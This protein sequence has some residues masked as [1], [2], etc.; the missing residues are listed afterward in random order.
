MNGKKIDVITHSSFDA[1]T[2]DSFQGKERKIVIYSLVVHKNLLAL[3]DFRRLNVAIT[4]AR[5]K[6]IILASKL[7]CDSEINKTRGKYYDLLH[8]HISLL[9]GI[10]TG[11]HS[12]ELKDFID[13][14]KPIAQNMKIRGMQLDKDEQESLVKRRLIEP[15]KT[16]GIRLGTDTQ[17]VISKFSLTKFI[18]YLNKK[19]ITSHPTSKLILTEDY[20][21]IILGYSPFLK[22]VKVGYSGL[23]ISSTD[24]ES[25]KIV[26]ILLSNFKL[27]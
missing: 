19:Y 25:E 13:E 2:V 5:E 7:L 23:I 27:Q 24:P 17:G 10:I 8:N 1:G 26:K 11:S 12:N 22:K 6:L 15:M 16:K 21:K 3:D 20:L 14:L 4:R 9:N 18:D